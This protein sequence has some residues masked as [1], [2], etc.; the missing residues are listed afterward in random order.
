MVPPVISASG[1]ICPSW[2]PSGQCMP[3]E[4]QPGQGFQAC[5]S[6]GCSPGAG[7]LS[8]WDLCT[9]MLLP[10][11]P[12]LL[13]QPPFLPHLSPGPGLPAP[14]WLPPCLFTLHLEGPFQNSEIT[15]SSI[16]ARPPS[17]W[18]LGAPL[19][20]DPQQQQMKGRKRHKDE[21]G[22]PVSQKHRQRA[23]LMPQPGLQFQ[24]P[25]RD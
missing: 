7:R 20:T 2:P 9:Q 15:K 12:S 8:G 24:N 11:M 6:T 14:G 10:S 21:A 4:G 16:K 13:P 5:V 17:G 18:S 3:S 19:C 22:P 23:G 1:S 25:A